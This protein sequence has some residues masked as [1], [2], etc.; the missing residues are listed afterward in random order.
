MI[1]P[2]AEGINIFVKGKCTADQSDVAAALAEVFGVSFI[3]L[4]HSFSAQGWDFGVLDEML[5]K[6]EE[7]LQSLVDLH[8]GSQEAWIEGDLIE[9]ATDNQLDYAL[10]QGCLVIEL[11]GSDTENFEEAADELLPFWQESGQ[12]N[13]I[14]GQAF[15]DDWEEVQLATRDLPGVTILRV[16]G[17]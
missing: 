7:S 6:A 13:S 12:A 10:S 2:D 11:A 15:T 5:S 14:I 1:G 9:L 8:D 3:F 16:T 4:G 17:N